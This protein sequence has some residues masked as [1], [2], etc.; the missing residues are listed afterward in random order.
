MYVCEFVCVSLCV[1]VCVCVC[2]CM[3]VGV[4]LITAGEG[5]G[6]DSNIFLKKIDGDAYFTYSGPKS[7][8][9]YDKTLT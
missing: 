9:F 7:S 2:V 3:C 4:V 8:S 6:G 1:C 5:G